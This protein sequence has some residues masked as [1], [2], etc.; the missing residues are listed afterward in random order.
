[1]SDMIVD[2]RLKSHAELINRVLSLN[3]D[4][5]LLQSQL[6][7]LREEN[8]RI[9]KQWHVAIKEMRDEKEQSGRAFTALLEE[10]AKLWRVVEA[11]REV[12]K[13]ARGISARMPPCKPEEEA[14]F[15]KQTLAQVEQA[16]REIEGK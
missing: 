11:A 15:A 2:L 3:T 6:F 10:N 13:T 16:L 7:A 8:E 14:Y 12:I 9:L 4:A 5:Q 1:M